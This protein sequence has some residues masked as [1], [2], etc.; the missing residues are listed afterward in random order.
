MDFRK[1][2][3]TE[4]SLSDLYKSTVEAFPRTLKRQFAVDPIK[5]V[6]IKWS[7]FLGM[8][9][10]SVSGLAQN[11]GHE[12][13]PS[14]LFKNVEYIKDL[15]SVKLATEGKEYYLH[16]L[17]VQKN[18][19]RVKCSCGDFFWRFR[20]TDAEEQCLLGPDRKKYE[21]HGGPPANPMSMPG[22]CKH[23][24]KFINALEQSGI[25]K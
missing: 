9:T 7:P 5:I 20:H 15:K 19:I 21:S 11:E 16:P 23:L 1:W 13:R 24:L 4:S 3:M 17:S 10:L 8:K 25:L 22:M 2:L 12:Y 6:E 18:D 14:I